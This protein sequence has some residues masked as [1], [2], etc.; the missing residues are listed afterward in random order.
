[1]AYE[2]NGVT[3]V[4][5]LAASVVDDSAMNGNRNT[6]IG[7]ILGMVGECNTL[8]PFVPTKIYNFKD[9]LLK[10]GTSDIMLLK[11]IEKAFSPSKEDGIASPDYIEFVNSRGEEQASITLVDSAA[12]DAIDV[13]SR[14][15][16]SDGAKIRIAIGVGTVG[17]STRKI[18][19]RNGNLP[20]VVADNIKN[21]LF[22]ITYVGSETTATVESVITSGVPCFKVTLGSIIT[23]LSL[24]TYSSI[25]G[26]V[27]ALNDLEGITATLLY[28]GAAI[29]PSLDMDAVLTATT[30]KSATVTVRALLDA[31]IN[32]LN[33]MA[34][35]V[36]ATRKTGLLGIPA[37]LVSTPLSYTEIAAATLE[38]WQA[39]FDAL[40][41]VKAHWIVPISSTVDVIEMASAHVNYMSTIAFQERRAV[42]GMLAG[43]TNDEALAFAES[44][45]NPRVTINHLGFYDPNLSGVNTLYPPI[46]LAALIAGM[47]CGVKPGTPL[48]NKTINVSEL[49]RRL[50]NPEDTD[51]LLPGGVFCTWRDYDGNIRIL[52]SVS[53]SQD[54]E[55]FNRHEM[56]VGWCTDYISW[57]LRKVVDKHRGSKTSPLKP[58]IIKS[59]LETRLN[60]M[61]EAEPVGD[62]VIAGD[63]DHPA[64]FGLEVSVYLDAVTISVSVREVLSLNYAGIN[65]SA[66]PYLGTTA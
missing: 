59:D 24:N 30:I 56:S 17:G 44:I 2:L 52:Q 36:T 3:Y 35:W 31:V 27:D 23:S 45:D 61:A 39:A 32:K 13:V 8:T 5:P 19:L 40:K 34:G 33:T 53:S 48:T 20:A 10:L 66:L 12:S 26:L 16:G 54:S 38:Q 11:A 1:M 41:N 21:D 7:Y 51:M 25:G 15:Y 4:T 9:A 14:V 6:G 43:S 18:T 42:I 29:K 22:S 55:N 50:Q 57:E 37:T 65:I 47:M 46:C 49:D 28:P 64:W 58:G 60:K 62:A 63:A